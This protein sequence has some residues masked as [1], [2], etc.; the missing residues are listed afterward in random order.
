MISFEVTVSGL[1]QHKILQAL[2]AFGIQIKSI[3]KVAHNKTVFVFD[4]INFEKFI[5]LEQLKNFEVSVKEKSKVKTLAFRLISCVGAFLGFALGFLMFFLVSLRV[6]DVQIA[7]PF[8]HTCSNGEK[9]VFLEENKAEIMNYLESLGLFCGAQKKEIDAK[10]IERKLAGSYPEIASA[11][12]TIK[13]NYAFV[14]L[15]EAT[16]EQKDLSRI[17]AK[18]ESTIDKIVAVS[19]RALFGEGDNVKKGETL[20]QS[21][22]GSAAVGYIVVT[23]KYKQ[24]AVFDEDFLQVVKKTTEKRTNLQTFEGVGEILLSENEFFAKDETISLFADYEVLMF[25][26]KQKE[27]K[28]QDVFWE[29]ENDVKQQANVCPGENFT[30][31]YYTFRLAQNLIEYV[32]E[33]EIQ[34]IIS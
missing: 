24:S 26:E 17:H 23:E 2:V 22:D 19:G 12:V 9:C 18:A 29:L 14:E 1:N 15:H 3:K 31:N 8:D 10:D 16:L 11:I 28:I 34:R 13:G 33:L 27:Q 5:K 20:I 25:D 32:C 21:V 6:F 7:C 30:M 4:K